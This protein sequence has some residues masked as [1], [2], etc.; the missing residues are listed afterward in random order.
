M[1]LIRKTIEKKKMTAKETEEAIEKAQQD[2]QRRI[3]VL[4]KSN[5]RFHRGKN[6]VFYAMV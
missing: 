6:F 4:K 1:E 5:V 2:G 3:E